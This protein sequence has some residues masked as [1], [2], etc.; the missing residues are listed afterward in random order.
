MTPLRRAD[1]RRGRR[2]WQSRARRRV[3][4]RPAAVPTCSC[5]RARTASAASSGSADGRRPDARRRRRGDA[6]PAP[7]GARPGAAIGLGDASSTRPR[8]TA[9]IWTRGALRPMPPTVMG[10]P[11]DVDALM[12][13]GIVEQPPVS[14]PAP[15]PD[16]RRLGRR[17]RPRARRRR[18]ARPAGGAA[19]GRRLRRPC[20]RAVAG[21]RRRTRSLRWATTCS[22]AAAA[23][24]RRRTGGPV[25]A[26]LVGGVGQLPAALAEASG[27]DVRT[28]R[29]GPRH[30]ADRC[31]LAAHARPTAER[32]DVDAVV[33]AAPAPAAVAAARGGGARGGVR[34]GRR[35][36]REHGDRHVRRSTSDAELDGLRLPGAAGRRHRHQGLD[37]LVATSGRGSPQ[38]GRT[39]L[40]A[41]VGPRRR[42]R[43]SCTRTTPTSPA[44]ALADL[45]R[46]VGRPA[47]AGALARAAVGRRRCRSTRS[48]TSTA[49]TSSSARSRPCPAWRC[50]ARPTAA[51][52]SRPSSPRPR[53]RA[54]AAGRL[55]THRAHGGEQGEAGQGD[56]RHDPLHDV[57]GLPARARP[58]RLPTATPRRPRSTP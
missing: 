17:V 35:H 40:R 38:P 57:V 11:A 31:R 51:S 41:S 52:A 22:R 23:R 14:R 25:F 24:G 55:G 37:V 2:R 43:R 50:A 45:R 47:R 58:R 28:R 5:S 12:A 32:D 4:A 19:A 48:A 20:R 54:A 33:V 18:G 6:G 8:S 30:R 46:A 42:H 16:E 26:G 10:I 36:L 53:R 15:A 1:A 34:A 56:Q 49:S 7:G 21:R 29:R 39:V 3:R 27:A 13:S 9:S 44:A